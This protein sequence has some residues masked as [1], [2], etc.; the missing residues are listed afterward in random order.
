M[1]GS[2]YAVQ[3]LKSCHRTLSDVTFKMGLS[4]TLQSTSG[5]HCRASS[6]VN[7]VPRRYVVVQMH[8]ASKLKM[9]QFN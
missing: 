9:H 6:G 3:S 7:Q 4:S 8:S 5:I 1:V 2:D